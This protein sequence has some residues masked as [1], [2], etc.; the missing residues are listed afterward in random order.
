MIV[1]I[2][3]FFGPHPAQEADTSLETLLQ[4]LAANGIA[5]AL[6]Y[7]RGAVLFDGEDGN[8]TT[9][10]AC[11][12]HTALVPVA[13]VDPR[14]WRVWDAI[15]RWAGAGCVAFR[16]IPQDQGWSLESGSLRRALA[17]VAETGRPALIDVVGPGHA[18]QA[19][20]AARG[21]SLSLVLMNLSYWTLAE[22]LAE[23]A[24]SPHV[25]LE[26]D[27][28]CLPGQLETMVEVVGAERL[29]FGSYA[30]AYEPAP[31][32]TIVGK[33]GVSDEAKRLILGGNAARLFRLPVLVREDGNA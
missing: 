2:D 1:D 12:A 24:D 26:A 14:V 17:A 21:L 10:A 23:A 27:R 31:T 4:V 18:A 7:F 13:V 6:V 19:A 33:A 20:R 30:P 11:R 32:L 16:F 9:L 3:T 29:L 15:P 22:A 28:V 25:Y 8:R 5:R